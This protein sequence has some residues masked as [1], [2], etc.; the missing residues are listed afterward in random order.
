MECH[1][2]PWDVLPHLSCL[3]A[4]VGGWPSKS[5]PTEMPPSWGILVLWTLVFM[6]CG[7][8]HHFS[9]LSMP[10]ETNLF[11][12]TLQEIYFLSHIPPWILLHVNIFTY[13]N[14]SLPWNPREL[15]LV[16]SS[17]RTLLPSST[18]RSL[19]GLHQSLGVCHTAMCWGFE[20]MSPYGTLSPPGPQ[21]MLC[22]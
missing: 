10:G 15:I 20:H 21:F 5:H 18:R 14:P 17:H 3:V 4:H 12:L 6:V 7:E 22:F 8:L 13:G 11:T 1:H 9:A 16:H 2:R 19:P